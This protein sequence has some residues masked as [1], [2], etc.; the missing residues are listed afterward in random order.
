[1]PWGFLNFSSPKLIQLLLTQNRKTKK[2]PVSFSV[3]FTKRKFNFCHLNFSSFQFLKPT[4][5]QSAWTR[6]ENPPVAKSL[7]FMHGA[8]TR[9][10][11]EQITLQI[12]PGCMPDG[13]KK[14]YCDSAKCQQRD[15]AFPAL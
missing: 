6:D 13:C 10:A 4:L 8:Q 11:I 9:D 1:M 15:L 5:L 2:F 3:S 12:S 7:K 14:L